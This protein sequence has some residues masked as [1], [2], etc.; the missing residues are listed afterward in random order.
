M[1]EYIS[2]TENCS[3][4]DA[5]EGMDY[6]KIWDAAV[7]RINNV[8]NAIK[9]YQQNN[10]PAPQH[11]SVNAVQGGTTQGMPQQIGNIIKGLDF[12]PA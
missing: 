4:A 7:K 11:K 1:G 12:L 10:P 5:L 8:S 6:S 2:D 3:F 9:T